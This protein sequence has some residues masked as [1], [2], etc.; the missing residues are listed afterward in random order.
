MHNN[1]AC[2]ML[3]VAVPVCVDVPCFAQCQA[4]GVYTREGPHRKAQADIV[5]L[6]VTVV[7]QQSCW[8]K[9]HNQQPPLFLLQCFLASKDPQAQQDSG[10]EHCTAKCHQCTVMLGW[11][12]RWLSKLARTN[13]LPSKSDAMTVSLIKNLL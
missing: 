10:K 3:S 2:V 4:C 7:N 1:V 5:V 13:W 12:R 9:Q 11:S 8:L 6:K